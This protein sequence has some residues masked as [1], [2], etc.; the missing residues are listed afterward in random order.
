MSHKIVD[1]LPMRPVGRPKEG[2]ESRSE[3][4]R[5][6]IEPYLGQ[7]LTAVCRLLGISK[8][9]ALRQGM[10]LFLREADRLIRS[11]DQL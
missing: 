9:E 6:R 7:R 8:S 4:L 2:A 11:Y 1:D 3:V 5:V 10:H